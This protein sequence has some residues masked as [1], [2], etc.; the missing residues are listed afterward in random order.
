MTHSTEKGGIWRTLEWIAAIIGAA[1]CVLAPLLFIG[2]VQ[3]GE[4]FPALYFIEIGV[5]GVLVLYYVAA[6]SRL[7]AR[8]A[9]VPWIASGIILVFVILAGFT[10]GPALIPALLAFLA[11][12]VL[13][14]RQSGG[15]EATHVVY[16]F[17]AAVAQAAFIMLMIQL[18]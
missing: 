9:A 14:G 2:S 15:I 13:A 5:V 11:V 4:L 1:T 17:A 10:I 12:G 6:R 18:R 7:G 3:R 16:G 8:W